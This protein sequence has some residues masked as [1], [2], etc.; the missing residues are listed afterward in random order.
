MPKK[1]T[2]IVTLCGSS[3]FCD[4]MAVCGWLIEKKENSIVMGLHL[5]PGWYCRDK[6]PDHLAEREGVAEQMDELHLRKIDLSD[7]V[8]VVNWNEYIGDSTKR[9]I[10]YAKK[11]GVFIRYFTLDPIGSEV[12]GIIKKA[13]EAKDA[14]DAK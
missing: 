8:F 7:E 9:E 10:K 4:I 11:K 2:R 14:D 12:C 3:R 1:K 6:I 13:K 5:L